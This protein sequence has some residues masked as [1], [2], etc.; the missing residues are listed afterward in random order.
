MQSCQGQIT[1]HSI[2]LTITALLVTYLFNLLMPLFGI[3]AA[4]KHV[5]CIT[6]APTTIKFVLSWSDNHAAYSQCLAKGS[7]AQ[8]VVG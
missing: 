3:G 4:S 8:H 2:S 7:Y 1:H 6:M 5:W